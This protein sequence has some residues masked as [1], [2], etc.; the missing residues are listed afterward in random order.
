MSLTASE[1]RVLTRIEEALLSRDPCFRSLFAIFTRLTRHE[2]MPA[3]EQLRRRRWHPP[4]GA[5]ILFA[6]ALI[7]SVIVLGS[8]ASA[9]GCGPV[10]PSAGITAHPAAGV[11]TYQG[12]SPRFALRR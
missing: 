7:A 10:Q 5:V 1:Q 3:I 6:I 4:T 11:P 9:N 2:S 8:V 12:C